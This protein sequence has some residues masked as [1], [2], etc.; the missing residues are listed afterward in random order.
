MAIRHVW[1][2]VAPRSLYGPLYKRLIVIMAKYVEPALVVAASPCQLLAFLLF[3]WNCQ[4]WWGPHHE[5]ELWIMVEVLYW[6]GE[7]QTLENFSNSDPTAIDLGLDCPVRQTRLRKAFDKFVFSRELAPFAPQGVL[8]AFPP[9]NSLTR[10]VTYKLVERSRTHSLRW[11]VVT[12]PPCLWLSW[13]HPL[14]HSHY[15]SS[16]TTLLASQSHHRHLL[17][18]V[19]LISPSNRSWMKAMVA[20]DHDVFSSGQKSESSSQSSKSV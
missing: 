2:T 12:P 17:Q 10:P 13:C 11:V 7:E 19:S 1:Y 14:S 4:W 16:L 6:R 9:G 20:V 5:E 18:P 3:R 8:S 15:P